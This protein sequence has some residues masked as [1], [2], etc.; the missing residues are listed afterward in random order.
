MIDVLQGMDKSEAA[1]RRSTNP[2]LVDR[3]AEELAKMDMIETV[4]GGFAASLD[5]R[6][7]L[8]YYALS[9][10]GR[11]EDVSRALSWRDFEEFTA[12]I[13]A[14]NGYD[15]ETHLVF[16]RPRFEVDLAARKEDYVVSV[17]CK[18]WSKPPSESLLRLIVEEQI[19]RSRLM[20]RKNQWIGYIAYPCIV[21]LQPWREPFY[22]RVPIVAVNLLNNFLIEFPSFEAG[23]FGVV[24]T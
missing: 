1:L 21:T 17:D 3:V 12:R 19:E 7:T 23:M 14:S 15:V 22:K 16:R 9:L 8:A 4:D 18:H 5:Q 20:L 13:F 11:V 24:A 10:G 6:M 2:P